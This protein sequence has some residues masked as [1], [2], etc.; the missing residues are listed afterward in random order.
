VFDIPELRFRLAVL[1]LNN[2][3]EQ[4]ALRSIPKIF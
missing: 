4:G 2:W 1:L 3:Q